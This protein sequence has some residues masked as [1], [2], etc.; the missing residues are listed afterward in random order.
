M[1]NSQNI[2]A[3]IRADL[4][5]LPQGLIFR[6]RDIYPG[7]DTAEAVIKALN[8]MVNSG[9][10]AKAA[11]GTFHKPIESRFGFLQPSQSEI[12]KDLLEENGKITGYLTGYSVFN[13]MG[14]TTQ[15]SSIIQIG[16]NQTR[17]AFTRGQFSVAIVSQR[18]RITRENTPLLQL[19]D[20]IRFIKKIPG[21]SPDSSC[22]RLLVL[23]KNLSEQDINTLVLLA[24]KY[25][26]SVRALTGALLEKLNVE[27]STIVLKKSLNPLT[28]FVIPG[29]EKTLSDA[30][31]NWNIK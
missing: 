23:L 6:Y 29:V 13:Q 26:P 3:K 28:N 5:K 22:R 31:R 1:E 15:V 30:S 27:V 8:R 19:L 10:L 4:A 16:K 20:A 24:L 2:S 18:N 25:S 11:K 17:P 21:S 9:L 12:I 14:L 7:N